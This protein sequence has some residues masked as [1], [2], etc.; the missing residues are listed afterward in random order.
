ML[1]AHGHSDAEEDTPASARRNLGY[2]VALITAFTLVSMTV[3]E[4]VK[5]LLFPSIKLW[6]SHLITIGVSGVI[7][8]VTAF[9][10]LRR[11]ERLRQ[12]EESY[13]QLVEQSP[14][15]IWVHRRGAIVFANS[16]CAAIFGASSV[17][18]LIGKRMLDFVHSDDR[19]AVQ[20]ALENREGDL[21]APLLRTERRYIGLDGEELEV[22][23]MVRPV[24]YQGEA[25]TQ[26]IFRDIAE[27][28]AAEQELRQSEAR[29]YKAF[30]VNPEPI[31]I[32]TLSEGR[33]VDV[34]ESFLRVTGYRRE[35]VIGHTAWEMKLW[36][37]PEDRVRY[38]KALKEEG[39]VRDMEIMFQTK[40]GAERAGLIS[41][42]VID[43]LSQKCAIAVIRDITERNRLEVQL[44]Q[45]QKMEAVGQLSGGIAHDFNNLLGVILGY[46]EVLETQLDPNSKLYKNAEQIKKA[47]QR[48]ASL[49][50][51]LLA[52]SRQQVLEPT[53]LA[54]NTIVVDIEKM[55]RRLIG[56]N[57]ELKVVLDPELGR[58]RADQG[59]IEQIIVNLA[60][61]ARDAMPQ[62]GTL[63]I[64]TANI[65]VDDSYINQHRPMSAGSFILLSVTDT[66]V[67]MDRETQVHI[68]EP[69]FTT[70][71]RGKGTGLGLA[72]VYGVVKQSGGFIW[73]Q[74]EPGHGTTFEVL[75]PRVEEPVATVAQDRRSGG[76]WRGS[77]TVLLVEDEESL[78]K[79]IL[80]MLRDNGYA[81][82]EAANA[83]EAMEIARQARGK[84]DLLLTDVVMP[85]MNG[86][87]LADQ[88]VSLYP[89]IKTLYMSGY[90]EFAVPLSDILQQERPLLQKPFTQ[91][92]LLRKIR[93]VLEN[94]RPPILASR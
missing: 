91:Q 69:F 55:L 11:D 1:H 67:G 8:T 56:E 50:R 12:S 20:E 74:S 43:I 28:K 76:A 48:A 90:T 49:T 4:L 23:T 7:A 38:L 16:A 66:G 2:R 41:A 64:E 75:L 9:F 13:R 45:A 77:R 10:A 46:S 80:G 58:V 63:T 82:L 52:F 6:E 29:F 65:E 84:I 60:V 86:S 79:L 94:S 93:E 85:G 21:S 73:V 37:R 26:V 51:Q 32:N 81:V 15:A 27:R 72:T 14:D 36:K 33:Y 53:V 59:Q 57:I 70:K 83:M 17:D 34:N 31:L 92:S 78:R 40:S 42:E 3:F 71:E 47:G 19:A 62:G 87:E 61:N 35:D 39:S 22:E 44:R 68:F 54:L 24:L 89:G 25:S 88:L 5:T 18:E 30:N